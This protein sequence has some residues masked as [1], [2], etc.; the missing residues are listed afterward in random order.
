LDQRAGD[1]GVAL[2]LTHGKQMLRVGIAADFGYCT[3]Q[4]K[5]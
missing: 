3:A 2:S 1:T 4:R 5:E